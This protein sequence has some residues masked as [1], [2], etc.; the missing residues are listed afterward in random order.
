MASNL[1]IGTL[2]RIDSTTLAGGSWQSTLPLANIKDRR[3]SKLART[4]TAATADTQFTMDMGQARSVGAMALVAHN[5]SVNAK[6][7]LTGADSSTAFTNLLSFPNDFDNAAWTKSNGSITADVATAPDGTMTADK[8][9][10]NTSSGVTHYI[11]QTSSALTSGQVVTW[12]CSIKAAER[13]EVMFRIFA[14]GA[15][16]SNRL[17]YVNLLTGSVSGN[18][19]VF[20]ISVMNQQNGWVN[21]AITATADTNGNA[22]CGIFT[23]VNGNNTYPGDGTSGIYLWGA[24]LVQGAGT[25]YDSGYVPVWPSGTIPQSLLEWED[26]NFWLGTVSQEAVA[27]FNAPFVL[28]LASPQTLRYW[29][30]EVVDTT[31]PSA[32]VQIGRVYIGSSWQPTYDRSYGA[33][34]GYED[35]SVIE[36]S[37]AGEEFFDVRRR[38]RGHRFELGFM[39][40]TEY[41]DRVLELQRLQ[42][43]T[44]E[45]LIVPDVTDTAN[46]A[47]VSFLGRLKSLNPVEQPYYNT[48]SCNLEIQE[49]L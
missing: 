11:A 39:S 33:S 1:L 27:G 3:L 5:L 26:D 4:S 25:T 49:I 18:T 28:P 45:V 24:Q 23:A 20:T 35:I 8:L 15:F 44:G 21:L 48:W 43:V 6:V 12:S 13:T 40:Q 32:Y 36:A 47:K 10:E 46:Q 38:R 37:L 31:N 29:K 22:T 41:M 34:M 7:R 2:N 16:T 17:C 30:I 9:V 42:G 19:G 14:V